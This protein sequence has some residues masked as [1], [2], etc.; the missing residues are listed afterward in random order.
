M[1]TMHETIRVAPAD[2]KSD[3]YAAAVGG[4]VWPLISNGPNDRLGHKIII[5]N[6]S[7]TDHSAKT[8]LVTGTDYNGNYYTE[9]I[10]MPRASDTTGS[11]EYFMTVSSIVPSASIGSDTMDIG[12]YPLA[13]WR[14]RPTLYTADATVR[15]TTEVH[16]VINYTI[17]E[18]F[19]NIIGDPSL[20]VWENI[21]AF[22]NEI[23]GV[24]SKN[25]LKSTGI[26]ILIN[27]HASMAYLLVN[28][29]GSGM[30]RAV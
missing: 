15:I 19:E 24:L 12:W 23:G 14:V 28:T 22:T 7:I 5:T 21:G 13:A 16:G 9:V 30:T 6:N 20:A 17:Q 4:D 8:I 10:P 11:A 27:S 26:R 2:A 29:I 1:P 3:G 18:C 25:T